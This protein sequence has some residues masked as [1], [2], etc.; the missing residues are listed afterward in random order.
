MAITFHGGEVK[1][2]SVM[3]S[4][5]HR[6]L[7]GL[8]SQSL[9]REP[10]TDRSRTSQGSAARDP[11]PIEAGFHLDNLTKLYHNKNSCESHL[12]M[13]SQT[14]HGAPPRSDFVSDRG[15]KL[16][17]RASQ[18]SM[19]QYE[20]YKYGGERMQESSAES[21]LRLLQ[22]PPLASDSHGAPPRVELGSD[23]GGKL[24]ARAVQ[25]SV[26]PQD[27]YN[28]DGRRCRHAVQRLV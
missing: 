2:A 28:Y 23:R 9:H 17:A 15:G 4:A 3:D 10:H 24:E 18:H 5:I 13:R 8:R 25:H 26:L 7:C 19:L 12:Y 14:A 21:H 11:P 16:E 6:S 20:N 22:A 27:Q 1:D